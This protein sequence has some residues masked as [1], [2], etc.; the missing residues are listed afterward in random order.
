MDGPEKE[1]MET[2]AR[3]AYSLAGDQWASAESRQE[4]AALLVNRCI[5]ELESEIDKNK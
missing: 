5:A 2:G 4:M 3:S 1:G